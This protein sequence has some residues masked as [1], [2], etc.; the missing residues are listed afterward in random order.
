MRLWKCCACS[1]VHSIASSGSSWWMALKPGLIRSTALGAGAGRHEARVVVVGRGGRRR[2]RLVG[3]PREQRAVVGIGREQVAERGGAAAGHAHQ[4]QRR[5]DR[6]GRRAR[7]GCGATRAPAAGW[8]GCTRT[9]RLDREHPDLV[10][11]GL[12]VARRP[13][14]VEPVAERRVAVVVEADLARDAPRAARR[15]PPVRRRARRACGPA[16]RDP[17]WSARGRTRRRRRRARVSTAARNASGV[18]QVTAP[19]AHSPTPSPM[20]FM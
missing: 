17:T 20:I 15:R 18:K 1:T 14:R 13:Q 9:W 11:V 4:D 5:L 8:P 16:R 19:A 6:R 3:L 10:E 7:D 12:L 2:D